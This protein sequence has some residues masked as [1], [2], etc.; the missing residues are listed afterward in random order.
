ME[1]RAYY[2]STYEADGFIHLTKEAGL[3]LGVANHFY[4]A[5]PDAW[6]LLEIDSTKLTAKARARAHVL[7][8]MVAR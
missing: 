2:P 6:Q 1:G 4:K 5:S 8:R 3:L 7:D